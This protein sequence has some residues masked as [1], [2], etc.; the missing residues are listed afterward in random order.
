MDDNY[1][2]AGLWIIYLTKKKLRNIKY[3]FFKE[4]EATI[5]LYSGQQHI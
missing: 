3:G 5:K 4:L 1:G 2:S